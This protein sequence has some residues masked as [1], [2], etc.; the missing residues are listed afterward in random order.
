MLQ[1]NASPTAK[2]TA[3]KGVHYPVFLT[4]ANNKRIGFSKRADGTT[5]AD[6]TLY[7]TN[8]N[9]DANFGYLQNAI[10]AQH[11]NANGYSQAS[12][13]FANNDIKH[14]TAERWIQKYKT[15]KSMAL[16]SVQKEPYLGGCNMP[17]QGSLRANKLLPVSTDKFIV[18]YNQNSPNGTYARIG[19]LG[20]DGTITYGTA[21]L[22]PSGTSTSWGYCDMVQIATDKFAIAYRDNASNLQ[23]VVCTVSGTTITMGTSIN[24]SIT[25]YNNV[26]MA[27]IATDKYSMSYILSGSETRM[28]VCTVSGTT[29]TAGTNVSISTTRYSHDVQYESATLG[30]VTQTDASG[31]LYAR[32][33]SISGTV[34]TFNT[35]VSLRNLNYSHTN[36]HSNIFSW[37]S[38]GLYYFHSVNQKPLLIEVV[39]TVPSVVDEV[40]IYTDYGTS[41]TAS[42]FTNIVSVGA[43]EYMYGMHTPSNK[44]FM[45]NVN[46]NTTTKKITFVPMEAYANVNYNFFY[47]AGIIKIGTQYVIVGVTNSDNQNNLYECVTQEASVELRYASESPAFATLSNAKYGWAYKPYSCAKAV[48][49]TLMYLNIK[50]V[51]GG[52][53]SLYF[54]D[55]TVE[56]D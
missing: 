53:R 48:N 28:T 15:L 27:K 11:Q 50:N 51:S 9:N 4:L 29:I 46:I 23:H 42:T 56:V 24:T 49:A 14:V 3:Q 21:V 13:V 34:P 19:T 36:N 2:N 44:Y 52:S 17:S 31:N 45:A 54:K 6:G 38:G 47:Y 1:I 33:I 43:T 40:S 7:P 37:I 26:R 10:N 41:T 8:F 5:D 30:L 22:C 16:A 25:S 39:A 55:I 32:S 18:L 35:E 12:D 20:S